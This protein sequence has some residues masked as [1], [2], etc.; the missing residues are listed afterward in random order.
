MM[1]LLH[2][3]HTAIRFREQALDIE[4]IF[5]TEGSTHAQANQIPAGNLAP[6]FN[7][8]LIQTAGLF[9]GRFGA[10]PGSDNDEFISTHASDVI[11]ATADILKVASK[12]LEQVVAFEVTVEVINLFEIVEVAHHDGQ[13]SAGAAAACDLPR[14]M[15][16]Q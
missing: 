7:G 1:Y 16:K 15:N 10:Q 11:I 8:Q 2:G 6:R 9:A 12:I 13:R 4:T 14:Q 3:V 5:R